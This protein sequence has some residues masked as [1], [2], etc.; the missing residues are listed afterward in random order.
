MKFDQETLREFEAAKV[1]ILDI[2]V[3]EDNRTLNSFY[4]ELADGEK[5]ILNFWIGV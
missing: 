1:K 3:S 4:V 2:H 5:G